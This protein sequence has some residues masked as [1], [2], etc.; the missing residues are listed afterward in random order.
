MSI[1]KI[2]KNTRYCIFYFY[3][4]QIYVY[5]EILKNQENCLYFLFI[6]IAKGYKNIRQKERPL[7]ISR[8]TATVFSL[9]SLIF[10][11]QATGLYHW[12]LL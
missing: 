1:A 2:Q 3:I 10:L 5:I 6:Q 4:P 7:P 8:D 9:V 11:P 12:L